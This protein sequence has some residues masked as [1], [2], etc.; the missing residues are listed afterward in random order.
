MKFLDEIKK[1]R[2][3][4][5]D[6]AM[7]TQLAE[8]GVEPGGQNNLTAADKVK[9]VHNNY[10]K[11]GSDVIITNTLTANRIYIDSHDVRDDIKDLNLKGVEIAKEA[12]GK[13]VFVAGD[14]SSTGQLMEPLGLY[15]EQQFIDSYKEQVIL[16]EKGG[17]DLFIIETI[18]DLNEALSALKACK[19]V[20]KLPVVVSI[21]FSTLL[22]GGRTIMGNSVEQCA[23]ILTDNGAD[24]LG[25]N[26]GDLDPFEMAKLVALYKQHSNLPF[27]AQPNAGKPKLVGDQTVFDMPVSRFAEGIQQCLNAGASLIGGCCGTSPEYI[28][29]ISKLVK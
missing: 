10:I 15:T 20:S 19:E 4:V 1:G 5:F 3:L 6:G 7:G 8:Q 9:N 13:N 29:A 14:I 21:T 12:A 11:N 16:L 22:N 26:C 2:I 23:K 24:C 25:A 17:V 28:N 18:M 27:L